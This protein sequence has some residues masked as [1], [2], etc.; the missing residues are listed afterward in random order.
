MPLHKGVPKDNFSA[1][2]RN[3]GPQSSVPGG[4]SRAN[5][6]RLLRVMRSVNLTQGMKGHS[7]RNP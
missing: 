5:K 1:R 4:Y 2:G 7:S 6:H 3:S